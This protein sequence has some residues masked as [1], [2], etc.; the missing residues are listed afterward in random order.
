[1]ELKHFSAV[2]TG[3]TQWTFN[4]TKMELKLASKLSSDAT[5]RAFNRTK[6][7]LKPEYVVITVGS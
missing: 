5:Q 7:E 4:R 1:M 3:I 6:M 2:A